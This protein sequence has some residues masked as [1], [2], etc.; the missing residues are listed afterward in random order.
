MR[1]AAG[2]WRTATADPTPW[3]GRFVPAAQGTAR[4]GERVTVDQILDGEAGA[5]AANLKL[6]TLWDRA[7]VL[8]TPALAVLPPK[9]GEESPYGPGWASEYTLP[10]NLVRAPAAVV[11]CGEIDDDGDRLPVAIQ[12]V[13]PRCADLPLMSIATAAEALLA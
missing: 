12:I 9:V 4:Y 5:H 13:A 3:D 2:S 7:D 11:R 6:A 10:F 8:I 1:A